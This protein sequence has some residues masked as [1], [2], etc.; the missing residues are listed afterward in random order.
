M[1][2]I[3]IRDRLR[4]EANFLYPNI[5]NDQE[6]YRVLK[7]E[8][9]HIADRFIDKST[10]EVDLT[11]YRIFKNKQ[12]AISRRNY[13]QSR[14]ANYVYKKQSPNERLWDAKYSGKLKEQ[15]IMAART[16]A[17]ELRRRYLRRTW[18]PKEFKGTRHPFYIGES[19]VITSHG[20]GKVYH[21]RPIYHYF[22][23]AKKGFKRRVNFKTAKGMKF[24]AWIPKD[25]T[26]LQVMARV[27]TYNVRNPKDKIVTIEHV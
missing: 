2:I 23:F 19:R 11:S 9:N 26:S 10:G 18:K 20:E 4:K 1:D 5:A 17:D 21:H 3:E 14:F 12:R 13:A 24:F 7:L 27:K 15:Q 8:Y 6:T 25:Q 22:P 16:R